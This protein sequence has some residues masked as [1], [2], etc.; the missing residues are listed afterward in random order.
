[1]MQLALFAMAACLPV[2]PASDF[3]LARDLAPKLPGFA[4]LPPETR[5]GLAPAPGVQRVF[6]A[7]EL[8]RLAARWRVEV[9]E[10]EVCVERPVNPLDI[11]RLLGAMQRQLPQA[12]IGILDY[13]RAPVPEGELEFPASGLRMT[14]AGGLWTGAVRYAGSR[15]YAVW[16]RVDVGVIEARV[17][18]VEDLKAG[19]AIEA[20]QLRIETREGF[21]SPVPSAATIEEIAGKIP[22]R[23]ISAG[24]VVC[25]SCVEAAK[26]VA[27]GETVRVEVHFG[28]AYIEMEGRAESAGSTGQ[29]IP[30]LNPGTRRRF[31][32]RVAGKGRVSVEEER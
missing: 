19:R 29:T 15:R 5:M 32:A 21:P 30:V 12:R 7:A 1:M 14:P 23:P 9:A 13:S 17:V 10:P 28:G 8:R 25:V 20:S 27:R 18:A 4:S 31:Q 22:R 26:D 6:R 11:G 2:S 24:T 3:V 16:A